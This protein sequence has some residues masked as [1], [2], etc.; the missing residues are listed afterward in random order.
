MR[1]WMIWIVIALF[2]QIPCLSE[3]EERPARKN[4]PDVKPTTYINVPTPTLGG[5]QFWA[6]ELIFW[7][8]RIQKNILTGHYRLLDENNVR[9]AWGNFEGCRA[10]LDEIKRRDKLAPMTGKVAIVLHGLGRSRGNMNGMAK[11]LKE[12]SKYTVLTVGYPSA[13]A[14]VEQHACGLAKVLQNLE[15]VEEINLVGHS[16][17]NI[18]TRRYLFGQFADLPDSKPDPRIKRIVMVGAPNN[19][20]QFAKLLAS[21]TIAQTLMIQPGLQLGVG[22]DALA[23]KLSIPSVEFGIIAGGKGD[24]TGYNPLLEGDDDLVV[25]VA[26][27]RIPGA[28]DFLVVP[29]LHTFMMDDETIQKSTLKFLEHGHFVAEDQR[30]PIERQPNEK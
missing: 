18:V 9:H 22:W 16:L 13:I 25:A 14:E 1:S 6:D 21:N 27:T 5:K 4:D 8:W 17:G 19:G 11:F 23:E 2:A 12:N 20:A 28:H 26:E 15:G 30:Q 24:G 7:Q 10:A 29:A 3:A